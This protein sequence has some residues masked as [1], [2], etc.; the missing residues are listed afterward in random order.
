[1]TF[2]Y[3]LSDRECPE[4]SMRTYTKKLFYNKEGQSIFY[5][6]AKESNQSI[7]ATF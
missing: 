7:Y 1:M 3:R 4:F 6:L 2:V 5:T